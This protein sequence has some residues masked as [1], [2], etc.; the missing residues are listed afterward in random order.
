MTQSRPYRVLLITPLDFEQTWNNREHNTAREY[1]RMGCVVT[2][3]HRKLNQSRKLRRLVGDALTFRIREKNQDGVRIIGVDPLMNYCAGLRSQQDSAG[4]A[5]SPSTKRP[6]ANAPT[7][8]G[9]RLIR[10]LAPLAFL[11]DVF[12][13]PCM[14]IALLLKLKGSYDVCLGFGPWGSLIGRLLRGCRR[15]RMLVYVDRDFEPGL[16][17]DPLRRRYTAWL[18][19][20][21]V[22]SADQIISI[23]H[24]LARLR[25]EQSGKEVAVFPTGVD[26]ERFAEA[27]TRTTQGHTLVHVGQLLP[28]S[29]LDLAIGALPTIR[30]EFPAAKLLVIGTGPEAYLQY[31][32]SLARQLQVEEQVDFRG[33]Q[34]NNLLPGLFKHADIALANAMPVEYRQYAYPLKVIEYMASGLPV[35]ATADTEAGDLVERCGCGVAVAYQQEELG[36]AIVKLFRDRNTINKMRASGANASKTMTWTNILESEWAHL[37]QTAL[38]R[39][40]R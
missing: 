12:F 35:I 32:H 29:G 20:F 5:D 28:W 17:T 11:R 19:R 3:A 40:S 8:R 34:P 18:E 22:R 31:L 37:R 21:M 4:M 26:W 25:K 16:L 23:G 24:R 39:R 2:V 15:V 38:G 27:R 36:D 7:A 9:N 30:N 10:L 6:S 33:T 14:L 1:H 13:V